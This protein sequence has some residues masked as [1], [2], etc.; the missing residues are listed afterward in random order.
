MDVLAIQEM[1]DDVEDVSLLSDGAVRVSG[2]PGHT[3]IPR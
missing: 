2:M 3:A 1:L